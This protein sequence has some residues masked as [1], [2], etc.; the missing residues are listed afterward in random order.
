MCIRD[1]G[2]PAHAGAPSVGPSD[3]RGDSVSDAE[4]AELEQNA[5]DV[6]EEM[7]FLLK[8]MGQLPEKG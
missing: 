4:P 3:S 8:V 5:E 1:R 2:G 6:D 7:S